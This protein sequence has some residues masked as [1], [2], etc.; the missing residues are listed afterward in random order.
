[1]LTVWLGILDHSKSHFW[2]H[3]LCWLE[4]NTVWWSMCL[5]KYVISS[6]IWYGDIVLPITGSL[7]FS[8]KLIIIVLKINS[9]QISFTDTVRLTKGAGIRSERGKVP[10]YTPTMTVSYSVLQ[11]YFIII[12]ILPF[13]GWTC[14][15]CWS[16]IQ[17]FFRTCM[18]Q[19]QCLKKKCTQSNLGHTEWQRLFFKVQSCI[20][21]DEI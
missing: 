12:K 19:T 9:M 13:I 7:P 3:V 8:F 21:V 6:W 17:T 10:P 16:R 14:S 4:N 1:M 20:Y 15:A 2:D 18:P 11:I 5:V